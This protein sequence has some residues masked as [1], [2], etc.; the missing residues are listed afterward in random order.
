[1]WALTLCSVVSCVR[2]CSIVI[3]DSSS[4]C[5]GDSYVRLGALFVCLEGTCVCVL[6]QFVKICV[7]PPTILALLSNWHTQGG[8]A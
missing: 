8:R 2:A 3:M 6:R 4:F 1:M 5:L 7:G